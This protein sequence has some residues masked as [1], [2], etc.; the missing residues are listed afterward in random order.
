MMTERPSSP[1]AA[2][3]GPV[4]VRPV[5]N[6]GERRAPSVQPVSTTERFEHDLQAFLEQNASVPAATDRRGA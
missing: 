6:D 4:G 1:P 2:E 3:R 5:P